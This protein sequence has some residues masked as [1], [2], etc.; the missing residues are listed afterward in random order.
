MPRGKAKK[1]IV[2]NFILDETASMYDVIGATIDGFNEYVDTLKQNKRATILFSLTKFNSE[3][4]ESVNVCDPISKIKRL[5]VDTYQ[6]ANMTPLYDAIGQTVTD[7]EKR[8]KEIKGK[9]TV[10]CVVQTDGWENCSQRFDLVKIRSLIEEKE[11]DGWTFVYLGANQDAW[12]AGGTMGISVNNTLSYITTDE[13]TNDAFVA[14]SNATATYT[15]NVVEGGVAMSDSSFFT[16]SGAGLDIRD[17]D[18][19]KTI[20]KSDT[21]ELIEEA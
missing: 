11:R 3:K 17:A 21:G 14:L 18:G 13:S 6:P 2:V 12:S 10:L 16:E 20:T 4:I 19:S 9:P 15:T 7:T 5:T 8:L 1:K